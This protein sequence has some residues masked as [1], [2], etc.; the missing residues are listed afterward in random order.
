MMGCRSRI[1]GINYL[2]TISW[3]LKDGPDKGIIPLTCMELFERVRL[4][5]E[6]DSNLNFTVEVSYIEVRFNIFQLF[7]S[8]ILTLGDGNRST[9]RKCE[10]CSIPKILAISGFVSILV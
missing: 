1:S 2:L 3:T 7:P 9:T 6:A 8:T 5:K 10:T 4:K